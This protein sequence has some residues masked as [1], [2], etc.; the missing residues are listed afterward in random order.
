MA[1][2]ARGRM[3]V[4]VVGKG[5]GIVCEGVVVL[6]GGVVGGGME[7]A[8][9]GVH[10]DAHSIY[11]VD[12]TSPTVDCLLV[13]RD[14]VVDTGSLRTPSSLPS[15]ARAHPTQLTKPL[16][17]LR[18]PPGAI[19]VPGLADAHAHLVQYGFKM[20]LQL[21]GASSLDD[22]LD[23]IEAYILAH[24]NVSDDP[25]H[26][27]EGMG[28]DQTRWV[29]WRGGF[30]TAADLAS[31]PLLAP[32]PIVLYRVDVHALWVSPRALELTRSTIPDGWPAP[33]EIEGG[34][35][36]RDEDNVPTG[37]FLDTAMALVPT[38]PWSH[39]QLEEYAERAMR[40]A[41]A[42]G[43]TNVHDAATD[44]RMIELFRR[45]A[46]EG[47]LPIRIYAMGNSEETTYWGDRIPRLENYGRDARLDVRSVKLF[48]DGALGSWGAALLEPYTDKPTTRGLMRSSQAALAETVR[49][50]WDDG[51][52]VNIHCIGDR[53]NKV[54]LD[55]F[56]SLAAN[57]S[58]ARRRPRIEHAQIMRLEDLERVGRLGDSK[59]RTSDMW[60]AESRLGPERIKGAYA[61]QSLLQSSPNGILP[62]GSDFPVENINPL[63][64]FYAAVS[65][66]DVHGESPHGPQG[67]FASERL[68]RAQALKGMTLDAAYAAFA[69]NER[70]SLTAGKK[71]DYVILDTNIMREDA[72]FE[73][74]LKTQVRATVI[75]GRVM[76]GGV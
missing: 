19:V 70:G 5:R 40:D 35:I 30:P 17:V 46:D 2:R 73:D 15:L 71:A 44:V 27:V 61:Y 55:I 59:N 25:S 72:P 66:L 57:D 18:V 3:C 67:W 56:E 24:P 37:V 36:I 53:A 7:R 45:M 60:Y 29:G 54:V 20:Q 28:W 50:F 49:Q 8:G 16:P 75:D 32:R 52:S 11:T 13:R 64:G 9:V 58:I 68:T 22:V 6:L 69:E 48:T 33:G 47:R 39:A 31:R 65:R 74:I 63:L 51:W 1:G 26:W 21:D 14:T 23:R 76:Y 12:P 4:A 42:V 41:L 10:G 38:P 62:L 34:E 43:L